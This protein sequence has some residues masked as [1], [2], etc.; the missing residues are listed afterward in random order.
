MD[1]LY[2]SVVGVLALFTQISV[3]HAFQTSLIIIKLAAI[4]KVFHC[5]AFTKINLYWTINILNK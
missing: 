3:L 5:K 2:I 1:Q 4:M